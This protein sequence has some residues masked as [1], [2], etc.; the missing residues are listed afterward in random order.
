MSNEFKTAS[1][2]MRHAQ[3]FDTSSILDEE[4]DA[5]IVAAQL[6]LSNAIAEL[7]TDQ[8]ELSE[9][10]SAIDV[11]DVLASLGIVLSSM[12]DDSHKFNY[13]SIAYFYC[14]KP[15]LFPQVTEYLSY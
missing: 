8:L 4:I 7:L 9:P 12:E 14:I 2:F 6:D 5:P 3:A 1:E 11:L 13:A 15:E 10:V